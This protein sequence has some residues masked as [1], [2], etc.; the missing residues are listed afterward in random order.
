MTNMHHHMIGALLRSCLP[1]E[2]SRHILSRMEA[3]PA[4][5]GS[6]GASD[7]V[8]RAVFAQALNAA[9]FADLLERVPSGRRY[10]EDRALAGFRI[11]FDHGALRTIRMVAGATG[12][13]PAGVGAFSR[14]LAPLGYSIADTYPLPRLKMTG[15]AFRHLDYPETIPQFFVSELHV[16][17]FD[18]SFAAA[19]QGV[20]GSSRDPLDSDALDVLELFGAKGEAPFEQAATALP[21]IVAAFGC[22]HDMPG[23]G[24]YDILRH[25]SAE[26]AWIAT[27]GNSFNHVTDR[28]GD[29]EALAAELRSIKLPIKDCVE[30]SASGRVRQTALRADDVVRPFRRA[31]GTLVQRSVPGS[32]YEFISRDID[33]TTGRLDLRFD[34]GNAT[35]IF[36][37]TAAASA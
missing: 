13:L 1:D 34:S 36:A 37:M 15:Y 7:A 30:V 20:F 33:P 29:V 26:A 4:I 32:F 9:L 18:A 25:Q 12:E 16:D 23:E 11:R 24:D 17:A 5:G 35:G 14:I 28:V 22:H 10:V 3:D 27:E 31:D 2:H 6:S 8:P 19:A 21:T